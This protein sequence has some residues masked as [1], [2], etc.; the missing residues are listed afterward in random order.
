M[1]LRVNTAL[2]YVYSEEITRVSFLKTL[3]EKINDIFNDFNA[4]TEKLLHVQIFTKN[5]SLAQR[6]MKAFLKVKLY[7]SFC[8]SFLFE[9]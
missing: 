7:L 1:Q 9:T 8:C 2:I 5:M 3:L 4:F 6:N